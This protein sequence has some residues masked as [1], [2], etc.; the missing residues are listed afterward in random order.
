LVL[1]KVTVK[2]KGRVLFWQYTP[3]KHKRFGMKLHKLCDGNRYLYDMTTYLEQL[4]N[5]AFNIT[6]THGT[7]LQLTRKIQ[8]VGHILF[9]DNNFFITST[10]F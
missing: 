2:L 5:A 8:G 10:V 6:P 9:M 1:D 4:L 7:V 3:K